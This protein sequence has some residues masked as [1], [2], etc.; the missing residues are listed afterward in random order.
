MDAPVRAPVVHPFPRRTAAV[1]RPAPMHFIALE[2]DSE[3]RIYRRER[4][5][6]G[7]SRRD[8][9]WSSRIGFLLAGAAIVA[10]LK[11]AAALTW[12]LL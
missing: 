7:S 10:A 9:A 12:S 3:W 4:R 11:L 2:H 5:E 8:G 1:A 6:L